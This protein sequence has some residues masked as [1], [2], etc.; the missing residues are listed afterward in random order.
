[1]DILQEMMSELDY[2]IS[3]LNDIVYHTPVIGSIPPTCVDGSCDGGCTSG[4][5]Q[6]KPGNK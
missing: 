2:D 5:Y 4:C 3:G 1:M 6:C